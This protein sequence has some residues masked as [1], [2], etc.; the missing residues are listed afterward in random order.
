[1]R[2]LYGMKLQRVLCYASILCIVIFAVLALNYLGRGPLIAVDAWLAN[3]LFSIRSDEGVRIMSSLTLL[4]SSKAT[5]LVVG[6]TSYVL[7]LCKQRRTAVMAL[8]GLIATQ[9]FTYFAKILFHRDR[10]SE[11]L[12]AVIEDSFSFPSGHA[13]SVAF[14]AGILVY[15]FIRAKK[16]STREKYF[17][18]LLGLLFI[19]VIDF[20]RLYLG[21]HYLTDVIAGNMVG[22][23][24]VMSTIWIIESALLVKTLKR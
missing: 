3:A 5:I 4:A 19:V 17:A 22:L 16:R 14:V 2:Y 1:M 23:I 8:G 24:G 15:L 20:S 21:V 7:F 6:V 10:P 11:V 18:I 12:H 9:A 13:T